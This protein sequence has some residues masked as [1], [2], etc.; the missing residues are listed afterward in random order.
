MKQKLILTLLIAAS[1]S[2]GGAG[3]TSSAF[4][5]VPIGATKPEMIASIGEPFSIRELEDGTVEYEYI[6]RI[7]EGERN[8]DERRYI[9]TMKNGKVVSKKVKQASPP[10]FLFDSYQM[11]TTENQEADSK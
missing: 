3:V 10:P 8:L 7:K 9:I 6:E 1:C 2:S 5:D 4:Y 11:Q